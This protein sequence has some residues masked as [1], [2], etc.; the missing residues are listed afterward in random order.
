MRTTVLTSTL[1]CLIIPGSVFATTL[2]AGYTEFKKECS[3]CHMPFPPQMLPKRSWKKLLSHLDQHFETDAG[4]DA[5]TTSTIEHFLQSYAADS[6]NGGRLGYFIAHSIA[7]TQTPL[8][9]TGTQGWRR[10][11][12][13]IRPSVW[14]SDKIKTRSNCLACHR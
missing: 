8:R 10:I 3:D 11:H 12:G 6:S 7:A 1:L 4:L 2:P 9:I 5:K 13:E 14:S